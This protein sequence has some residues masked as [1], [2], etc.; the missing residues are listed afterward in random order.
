MEGMILITQNTKVAQDIDYR[1]GNAW[2]YL[3][4]SRI[5]ALYQDDSKSSIKLLTEGYYSACSPEISYDGKFMIFAAQKK[6]NDT[7]QIYEMTLDNLKTRQV[8]V[9]KDNCIDPAYLPGKRLVFSKKTRYDSAKTGHSL[10]TC[11]IDGSNIEQITYNPNTHFASS[12]MKDGRVLTISRQLYPNN[13]DGMLMALRPDGSKAE[14]FYKGSNGNILHS[15]A[16]ESKNGKLIFIESDS[17]KK[18]GSNI[19]SISYNRP[20]HSRVNLT[21]AMQGDFYSIGQPRAGKL[22]V[23]YR[24]TENDPYGLYEFD[25]KKKTLGAS[26]YKDKKYNVLDIVVVHEKKRPKKLPSEV[27]RNVNTGLLLCQDINYSDT[28][29][30]SNPKAV[31]IEVLGIDSSL[32][33]VDVEKDGSFY[34]K[35]LADTPF[36]IRT[37]DEKGDVVSGPGSWIYLRPNERRGCVGCH[38]NNEQVP[39]N[40]QPISVRKEPIILPMQMKEIHENKVSLK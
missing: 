10:F 12:V 22:L 38:E 14:L 3:P 19:V 6:Q 39:E 16:L 31:K 29:A 2:R 21:S 11:N 25:M 4:E 36:R 32:G 15:R 33:V 9:S 8:T 23:S 26:I 5:V 34:L 40:R 20:L 24:S 1:T 17:S 18:E 28:H 13:K 37:I 7:W 30:S 35:V 27:D